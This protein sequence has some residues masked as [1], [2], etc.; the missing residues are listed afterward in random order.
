LLV[1]L[2]VVVVVVESG[3]EMIEMELVGEVQ[4]HWH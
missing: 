1:L 2:V 4:A 3:K